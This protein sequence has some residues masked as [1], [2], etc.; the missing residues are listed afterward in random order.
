MRFPGFLFIRTQPHFDS[1]FAIWYSWC[2]GLG[3]GVLEHRHR[4]L[5][6]PSS[7]SSYNYWY[8]GS[9][10][11]RLTMRDFLGR[12]DRGQLP[13]INGTG[14]N[15]LNPRCWIPQKIV[16]DQMNGERPPRNKWADG[17][18]W[19]CTTKSR[20]KRHCAGSCVI[21][22]LEIYAEYSGWSNHVKRAGEARDFFFVDLILHAPVTRFAIERGWVPLCTLCPR[23]PALYLH[24][25]TFRQEPLETN[26]SR[27]T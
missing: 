17:T 19:I 22:A 24:H 8:P 18:V 6:T 11:F 13:I 4:I 25:G 9:L 20:P 26:K 21:L 3:R 12:C 27:S 2:D 23:T 5:S 7:L 10:F 1:A 15:E 14:V 16:P